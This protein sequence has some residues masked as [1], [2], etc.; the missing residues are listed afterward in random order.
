MSPSEQLHAHHEELF[1]RIKSLAERASKMPP[2]VSLLLSYCNEYF[3]PHAEAEEVTFYAACEDI[4]FTKG[5]V[6]E[7]LELKRLVHVID[8]A[9]AR[10]NTQVISSGI[11]DFMDL[12]SR[13]HV[14]EENSLM[15]RLSKKLSPQEFEA[16]MEEA[17]TIEAGKKISDVRA[18]FE[19]DHKRID[20]NLSMLQA[21]E[22]DA[23][24]A[25]SLYS[26]IRGQLL[27]HVELEE[28]ILFPA[29]A[30]NS[31]PDQA[32]PIQVMVS[33]HRE[34]TSCIS[35][36]SDQLD[37]HL[38]SNNLQKLIDL[39]AI[40]SK[41]EEMIMYPLINRTLRREKREKVY[42]DCFEKLTEV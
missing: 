37:A 27:N 30:D 28:T 34:I 36:P 9:F 40:H 13:H 14:E 33:E 24:A 16:L 2:D 15:P 17:H 26:K 39:L 12:L 31:S 42:K 1:G 21:V 6:G 23:E 8:E 7:H 10:G 29:F 18:L 11:N 4:D 35:I 5:M 3:V 38:L 19:Y 32:G 41:K 22:D 20:L 25:I